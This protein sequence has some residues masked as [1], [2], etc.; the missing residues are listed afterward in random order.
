MVDPSPASALLDKLYETLKFTNSFRVPTPVSGDNNVVFRC[1][2]KKSFSIRPRTR[3]QVSRVSLPSS[4][5]QAIFS[6]A[7]EAPE[8][9][10]Y[11]F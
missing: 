3:H 1:P 10:F 8:P 7:P 9:D 11:R 5:I 2:V 6:T 4:F